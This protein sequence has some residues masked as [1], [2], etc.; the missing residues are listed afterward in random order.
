MHDR[1]PRKPSLRAAAVLALLLLPWVL[2]VAEERPPWVFAAPPPFHAGL[3]RLRSEPA[4]AP[5]MG[6]QFTGRFGVH[7]SNV[8]ASNAETSRDTAIATTTTSTAY[9]FTYQGQANWRSQE[10]SV[11]NLLKARYGR[12]RTEGGAWGENNDEIRYD[13]VYRRGITAP[14]FVYLGWGAE[15]V[16]TG[17]D[18]YN[19]A[20]DPTTGR[21]SGGYGQ[22]YEDFLPD[23]NH[24]EI[25]I[26][27]RA[28]RQWGHTLPGDS[29]GIETGLEGFMRYEHLL[30]RQDGDYDVRFFAQYEAF[31]EFNDLGHIT[32]LATAGL[33]MQLTRYLSLELG[34]RAYYETRPPEDDGTQVGYDQWSLRQDALF[35]FTYAY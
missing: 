31:S 18:P 6:W 21:A 14:H 15:S 29:S 30:K 10:D 20:F 34:L 35:G 8:A 16:F 1:P 7:I 24:F 25:R 26:G 11:G 17:P 28:Q 3:V 12:I 19:D 27:A 22:L 13:G 4:V 33:A 9:L 2:L 5:V 23:R 32:N